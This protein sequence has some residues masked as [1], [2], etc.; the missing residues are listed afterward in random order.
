M[1]FLFLNNE[2]VDRLWIRLFC[3]LRAIC[4][5][6]AICEFLRNKFVITFSFE[7]MASWPRFEGFKSSYITMDYLEG[8]YIRRT[9]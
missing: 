9:V 1:L 5:R 2:N 7:M 3:E 8:E 6:V 4:M